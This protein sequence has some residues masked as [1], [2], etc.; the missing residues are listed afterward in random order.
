MQFLPLHYHG[1]R[2]SSRVLLNRITRFLK[3]DLYIW[4]IV[5][6]NVNDKLTSETP[7]SH[8]MSLKIVKMW[9]YCKLHVKHLLRYSAT[10]YMQSIVF[11]IQGQKENGTEIQALLIS[12]TLILKWF[13]KKNMKTWNSASH[14]SQKTDDD[15]WLVL[16]SSPEA[17]PS[18]PVIHSRLKQ[19]AQYKQHSHA[20]I[21]PSINKRLIW[22]AWTI[23]CVQPLERM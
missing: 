6:E 9:M 13:T 11:Y 8:N 19:T 18:A 1:N 3:E 10:D 2:F 22:P 5:N 14:F 4:C 7:Y 17:S 16:V 12:E 20:M 15:W 21:A 23:F